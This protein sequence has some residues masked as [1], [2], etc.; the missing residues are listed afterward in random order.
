MNNDWVGVLDFGSQY[1]HLIARA[2]RSCGVYSKVLRYDISSADILKERP[3]AIILSG[4]PL[5]VIS[6]GA[7]RCSRALPGLGIPM[8]GICYGAQLMAEMLGGAVSSE[9]GIGEFGKTRLHLKG[10]ERFFKQLNREETVWM[11]HG[12]RISKL[13]SGFKVIG[14]TP[15]APVAAM[16]DKKKKL[17]GVQFHPEVTH[18]PKG[19]TILK[20]F[21]I[22]IAGCSPS[23]NMR[24]FVEDSVDEL[25]KRLGGERV[26]CALSGGVDS[27]VLAALLY[28]AIGKNLIAVFV[29]TG[30]LRKNEVEFVVE[31]FKRQLPLNLRVVRAERLFLD[32]LKGVTNPERKRVI[33]G[34][35]FIRIFEKEAKSAGRIKFLAQG[36]LYPD[37]IESISP[38]GGPSATIKTHHNVGGLPKRMNFTVIEPLRELFK[39]EVRLVGR[40]LKLPQEILLRQPFP[41]PGLA[42]RILGAV[43]KKEAR[44]LREADWVLIDEIK[45]AGIYRKLWQSFCVFLPVKTVG[46]MGDK[47]TY[48][49]VIA[50]RAVES[51]DAMTAHWAKLPYSLLERVAS[52][53]VNEVRGVNRVV[54]DISSKPPSTIEWE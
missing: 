49:N 29:D 41:G 9:K 6:P 38:A 35:H 17:Y 43:T 3:K 30:L 32:A 33:I 53:I 5:S 2:V 15:G 51:V 21:L 23:W 20:N 22:D 26:I 16:A 14:V 28:K 42:I 36:T 45:K 4:G 31:R 27:S 24:S 50:V 25:R 46:V 7:P 54:Y 48:E 44:I 12:D 8:L 10:K 39:D 40:E 52:R 1:T 47:R 37:V 18:T 19:K 34:R 13:P 11:S